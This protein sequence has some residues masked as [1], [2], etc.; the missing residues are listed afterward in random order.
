M[1]IVS[2]HVKPFTARSPLYGS[3]LCGAETG[4]GKTGIVVRRHNEARFP[5][6]LPQ[7]F[8][9][10]RRDGKKSRTE[11]A[12]AESAEVRSSPM[13]ER[14]FVSFLRP[15]RVKGA[16]MP[17]KDAGHKLAAIVRRLSARERY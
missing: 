2:S 12:G 6:Y 7:F 9:V 14:K 3:R 5:D 10:P 15:R 1:K 16:F 11:A 8:A 13:M 17:H 4:N